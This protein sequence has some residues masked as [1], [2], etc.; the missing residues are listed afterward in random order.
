[1]RQVYEDAANG[2][3]S[4]SAVALQAYLCDF[5]GFGIAESL[6][7]CDRAAV[8][9]QGDEVSFDGFK[10]QY[11]SLNPF[12][13]E[14]RKSEVIFRKQGPDISG[15]MVICG[16]LEDCEVYVCD[17]Q[18]CA[19]AS[20]LKRCLVLIGPCQGP[21]QV[22]GCEDCI[23]WMAC[24]QLRTRDCKRCTFH[25]YSKTAPI[26]ETSEDLTFAPWTA[27]YPHC[28]P[29]FE[30]AGFDASRNFWNAVY[31]FN[32]ELSKAHWRISPL[33]DI[34]ELSVCLDDAP[35]VSAVASNPASAVTHE[36][37][38][39]DPVQS[40]ESAGEAVHN[41]PQTR[42]PLPT[43]PRPGCRPRSFVANDVGGDTGGAIG[44]K[45]ALA[46]SL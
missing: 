7:I 30:A 35:E 12:K 2:T 18:D 40:E 13:I 31:D 38:C 24:Q 6:A 27:R 20:E 41:A 21:V 5:L 4:L 23:F 39:A 42:P 29:Q 14:D 11:P 37:L 43:T 45:R 26:I 32:G 10:V 22:H 28:T 16:K 44:L 46:P 34:I 9:A 25:L 36:A 15:K 19:D 3:G 17:R 1:M 33:E 8:G